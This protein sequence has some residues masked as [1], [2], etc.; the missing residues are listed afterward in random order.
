MEIENF[1]IITNEQ[2]DKNLMLFIYNNNHIFI[3]LIQYIY[4]IY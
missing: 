2:M 3:A 1:I 4:I